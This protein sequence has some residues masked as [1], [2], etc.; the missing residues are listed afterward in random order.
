MTKNKEIQLQVMEH[1]D[2][3][4]GVILTHETRPFYT[5]KTNK[6]IKK[7][8]DAELCAFVIQYITQIMKTTYVEKIVLNNSVI[9]INVYPDRK[10]SEDSMP[11]L[12]FIFNQIPEATINRMLETLAIMQNGTP[13]D[14]A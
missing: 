3:K 7:K 13:K 1:V 4:R 8:T 10:A 12:Q 14:D 6:T 9:I 5:E 11:T 2:N